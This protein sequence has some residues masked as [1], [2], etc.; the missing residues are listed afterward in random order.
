MVRHP[1]LRIGKPIESCLFEGDDIETTN[2][3]G[4]FVKDKLVGICSFFKTS[5]SSISLKNQYQ[6]RGMAVLKE[7]QGK[8][9]GNLIL[10]YGETFLKKKETNIIWCNA[11]EIA[12]DFYKKNGYKIIGRAFNIKGIGLHFVMYKKL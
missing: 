8:G 2:H 12:V 9:L 5:H 11:R 1:I 4:V 6:L 3:L 10:N 7:F